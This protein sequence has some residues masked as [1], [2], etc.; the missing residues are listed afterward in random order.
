[1]PRTYVIIEKKRRPHARDEASAADSGFPL[2]ELMKAMEM[3]MAA[4]AG[5]VCA[6]GAQA[7]TAGSY[8]AKPIRFIVPVAAGG[9]L[10]IVARALAQPVGESLGQ[11]IIVENR[12]GASSLV[13]TQFVAKSPPD[14][15][16]LL[17]VANTFAVVPSI[18]SNPGYDPLKD[19][20]PVTQT[21]LVPQVIIV[22]PSLPVRSI[23]ELIALAKARPGQLTYATSG[24]GGTGHM[25]TELF[26]RQAGIRMLHVPYKGNAPALIDVVGG[27]VMLMFD[28]IS[29]SE[30]YI[31]AGR[32]RALAVTSLTR[33][34]LFPE[35]PTVD[36]AGLRGYEDITLNGLMAPAGTPRELRVRVQEE[37]AKAVRN[38]ALRERFLE[39]GIELKASASPEDFA[40]MIKTEF[41]KKATLAREA[42]IKLD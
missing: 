35:L 18:V 21:C 29:T 4:F 34:S 26:D 28:Q 33:S 15:Y 5:A 42:G 37:I 25:A 36:E 7:Q 13:G 20:A 31:K 6:A 24:A 23:K 39:R 11:Q 3:V 8:P 14:G 9:N 30:Q 12:P 16:I 17:I 1:M 38:P 32:V 19:F 2:E 27:Q 41:D 22:N 10:D 40:A